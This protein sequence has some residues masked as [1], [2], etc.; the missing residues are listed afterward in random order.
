MHKLQVVLKELRESLFWL[1]LI[2][3]AK[4]L[5]DREVNALIGEASELANIIG[6]SIMTAKSN[7]ASARVPASR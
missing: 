5:S 6:K 1:R 7:R 3:A 4:R 2:V